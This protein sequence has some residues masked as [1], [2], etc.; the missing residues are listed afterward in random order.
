MP[1]LVRRLMN[2]VFRSEHQGGTARVAGNACQ[3][4]GAHQPRAQRYQDR[5]PVRR[6]HHPARSVPRPLSSSCRIMAHQFWIETGKSRC[7]DRRY[8][9]PDFDDLLRSRYDRRLNQVRP[10]PSP[11]P[12]ACVVRQE[13]RAS[14][15]RAVLIE[16]DDGPDR[17]DFGG[18]IH[19]PIAA[20]EGV[21]SRRSRI[22]G[23]RDWV[24]SSSASTACAATS[25]ASPSPSAPI[26]SGCDR[27][28]RV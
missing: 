21:E 1:A 15:M 10:A 2:L 11:K 8:R 13:T 18:S 5:S 27:N 20:E 3:G 9:A 24:R 16:V 25:S 23:G 7:T 26:S 17:I 14:H 4:P 22:Y 19:L 6:H 12:P 28:P